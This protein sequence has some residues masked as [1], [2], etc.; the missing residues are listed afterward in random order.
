VLGS[1]EIPRSRAFPRCERSV[2]LRADRYFWEIETCLAVINLASTDM[3]YDFGG[4]PKQDSGAPWTADTASVSALGSRRSVPG[5][6][7][8]SYNAKNNV[9]PM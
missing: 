1:Q 4:S 3:K 7:L 6:G 5:E 9:S 8:S 2:W